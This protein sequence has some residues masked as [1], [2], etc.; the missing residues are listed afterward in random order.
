MFI[1][2]TAIC[3]LAAIMNLK[4]TYEF[5][6]IIP[7]ARYVCATVNIICSMLCLYLVI[8][9]ESNIIQYILFS[10]EAVITTL[11]GFAGVG[12]MLMMFFCIL[13]F[14]NGFF[15]EHTKRRFSIILFSWL[16]VDIAVYPVLGLRYVLFNIFLAFLYVTMY[17][18]IYSKLE[19]KLSYLLPE[20]KVTSKIK[21]L[22]IHGSVII[23]EKY[24]LTKRQRN[25]LES[26]IKE[27]LSYEQISQKNNISISVVKK[28]MSA[29]CKAFGV[30][31]REALLILLL[32]YKLTF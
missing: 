26:C 25:F 15:K 2:G 22:P 17:L 12:A 29:C 11:I 9:P 8:K 20:N 14:V 3:I 1:F 10:V 13:L 5:E 30:K 18:V 16:I 4:T 32:Q 21:D 24:G 7:H 28:E 27:G 23:L 19:E 6:C 31:N